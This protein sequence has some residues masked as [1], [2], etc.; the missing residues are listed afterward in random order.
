MPS[1]T[2]TSTTPRPRSPPSPACCRPAPSI[3]PATT[4]TSIDRSPSPCPA[5]PRRDGGRRRSRST[6]RRHPPPRGLGAT[7]VA[8][9]MSS[10]AGPSTVRAERVGGSAAT[11][12]D[13]EVRRNLCTLAPWAPF[14]DVSL[15]PSSVGFAQNERNRRLRS[16]DR[17]FAAATDHSQQR[18][19]IRSSDRPFAAATDLSLIHI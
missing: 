10:L 3:P 18:Q 6:V 7:A 8:L 4:S 9:W 1:S 14:F 5:R 15:P 11:D 16:S 12:D 2:P 13:V 19:T 17:P